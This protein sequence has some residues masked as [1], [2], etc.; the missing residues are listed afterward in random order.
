MRAAR[1]RGPYV[2]MADGNDVVEEAP[3]ARGAIERGQVK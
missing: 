3:E 1:K 2:L